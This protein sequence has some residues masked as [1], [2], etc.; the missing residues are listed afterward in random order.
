[1]AEFYTF[2]ELRNAVIVEAGLVD[3]SSVQTYVEPQVNGA[4]Q[5]A[6][7]FLMGK[8]R[9]DHLSQ[10]YTWTLNGATGLVVEDVTIKEYEDIFEVK[11]SNTNR[12]IMEPTETAHLYAT[13][14]S[15]IYR[16]RLVWNDPNIDKLIKFWPVTATGS[17]DVRAAQL[18]EPFI[19]DDDIVPFKKLIIKL[20]ALWYLLAGDGINPGNAQKV[21]TMFTSAYDDYVTR[22]NIAEIGYGSRY[23]DDVLTL[24]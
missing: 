22:L 6:F 11:L 8:R 24:R 4:I 7:N 1:M 5:T 16:T 3:G 9:W 14:S 15:P 21:Q 17:V 12:K 13:G 18:P 23:D 10:W 2:K 19:G 20:G